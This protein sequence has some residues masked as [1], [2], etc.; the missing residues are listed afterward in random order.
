MSETTTATPLNRDQE[1]LADA[2]AEA[3]SFSDCARARAHDIDDDDAHDATHYLI[4]A[5]KQLRHAV[6]LLGDRLD[7]LAGASR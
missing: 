6:E 4:D 1:A 3:A 5:V 7:R 2:L